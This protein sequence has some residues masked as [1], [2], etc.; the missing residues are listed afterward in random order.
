MAPR[1]AA[2]WL[3]AVVASLCA[4][5]GHGLRLGATVGSQV[6]GWEDVLSTVK[7]EQADI[8]NE[9]ETWI[10]KAQKFNQEWTSS[11]GKSLKSVQDKLKKEKKTLEEVKSMKMKLCDVSCMNDPMKNAD[12]SNSKE[13]SDLSSKKI[14][15]KGKIAQLSAELSEVQTLKERVDVY[16][17]KVNK[18]KFTAKKELEQF[19]AALASKVEPRTKGSLLKVASGLAR[20]S[21]DHVARKA[22]SNRPTVNELLKPLQLKKQVLEAEKKTCD[23]LTGFEKDATA[24]RAGM[25]GRKDGELK[26]LQGN[27][28]T[29]TARTKT[30]TDKMDAFGQVAGGLASV[31]KKEK[32]AYSKTLDSLGGLEPKELK[33]LMEDEVDT[34]HEWWRDTCAEMKKLAGG[35]TNWVELCKKNWQSSIMGAEE[36]L[37]AVHGQP[38]LQPLDGLSKAKTDACKKDFKTE[39]E[40]VEAKMK[41]VKDFC[42][43]KNDAGEKHCTKE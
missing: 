40:G 20:E 11:L 31:C 19:E 34:H 9:A 7:T 14:A 8:W 15:A 3:T 25:S 10:P 21:S 43:T 18:L 41:E 29:Y 17:T 38:T 35:I 30:A 33:Q 6:A 23:G 13:A 16:A 39:L 22:S 1:A 24:M 42:E 4:T 36:N 37:E 28:D 2:G 5:P 12:F 27:I 32:D 26:R